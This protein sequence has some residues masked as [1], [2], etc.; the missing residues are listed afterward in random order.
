M[1]QQDPR[2]WWRDAVIYQV[3]VRSFADANGDGVGDLPG[4]RSRLPYLAELGVDALWINPFYTSPMDDAGY[5][6]ADYRDVDPLF[7]TLADARALVEE[8]HELSLKII[9]DLVPNHTSS[10][11][12][13]FTEALASPPGSRARARFH[14]QP[15]KGADGELPPNDWEA[16]FGGSAWERVVEADGTPG[17]WYLHLFDPSQPDLNWGNPEVHEEF[18]DILRFWLDLGVDGFR[19][20]VA[21][22]M[23]KADGLPDVGFARQHEGNGSGMPPTLP[24]F[25]QEA[26]H[27]IHREWRKVLDSY[28]PPRIAVAEAWTPT[29]G[30]HRAVRARGRAAPG[31]QLP[32]PHR[33]WSAARPA[34]GHRL[35]P[36]R[37]GAGAAHRRRGCCPTTTSLRHVTRYGGG[38]LGERRARA[39]ALLML[40]LP[41]SA[42]VYQGEEL[43][44][45]EVLDL[46]DEDLLQD[47]TWER[48][49][50]DR[51]RS[52]RLP[53]AG[54]VDDRRLGPAASDRTGDAVAAAARRL[55]GPVGAG[56]AGR[57][58]V[59][60]GAVPRGAAH[61]P[62]PPRRSAARPR[63][64]GGRRPPGC[65]TS[66]ARTRRPAARSRAW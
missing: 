41:G 24:Y 65:C 49:G 1:T 53:G 35:L 17:E 14:F 26:V 66:T 18:L 38:E 57:H 22:G 5:D 47:P 11:H 3:Y 51:A 32:L 37:H 45:P 4:I 50:P 44:L 8:A 21:H 58:R 10:A 56:A 9:V 46:P 13:W 43:G 27:E 64:P 34:R 54:A 59:H 30:A 28:E 25:D 33:E 63:W 52:R 23:V 60:A 6:V 19:V 16:V 2:Q 36:G 40:A 12:A 42:Y 48:V 15:G 29:V 20:D 55:V 7:G 61:P 39:A 62:R 31:V